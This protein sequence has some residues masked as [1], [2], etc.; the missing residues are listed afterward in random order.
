MM[1]LLLLLLLL[2]LHLKEK[3]LGVHTHQLLP[4]PL[5]QQTN[6]ISNN[7]QTLCKRGAA[8]Q[9]LKWLQE[10][11]LKGEETKTL[12]SE[13]RSCTKIQYKMN[14]DYFEL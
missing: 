14:N 3:T 11:G 4:Q 2:F 8:N 1:L 9:K 7:D 12:C 10:L 6:F 5:K 13:L